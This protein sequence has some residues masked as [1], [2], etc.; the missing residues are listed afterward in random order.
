MKV[1]PA[2]CVFRASSIDFLG[3]RVLSSGIQ[4]L[5][6]KVTAIKEFH[7]PETA[8]KL[9]EFLGLVNYYHLFIAQATNI[10]APLHDL[11]KGLPKTSHKSLIWTQEAFTAFTTIKLAHPANNARTTHNRRFPT[12]VGAVLQ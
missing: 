4:P 7:K 11:L 6:Q 1:H 3:H 5:P 9:R 10:L 8:K 12:A 2:K